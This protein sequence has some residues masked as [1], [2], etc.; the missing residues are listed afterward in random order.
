MNKYWKPW[1]QII[2]RL[3]C[4][5][6][7]VVIITAGWI[8]E[9]T[10][11]EPRLMT[12]FD[13][14]EEMPPALTDRGLFF[15]PV[16]NGKYGLAPGDGFHNLDEIP[17]PEI[18]HRCQ[19]PFMLESS[20][21]GNSEAAR[22]DLAFNSGLISRF[23]GTDRL[24]PTIRGRK[25]S[26]TFRF[27]VGPVDFPPVHSVQ[28]EV[29]GGYE[30]EREIILIEAKVGRWDSFH[31]RQLYYPYRFW[32]EALPGKHVR[33]VFLRCD[34]V[35]DLYCLYEFEFKDPL[36]YLSIGL[37]KSEKFKVV[38]APAEES[39]EESPAIS[40]ACDTT[41]AKKTFIP[42][43]D[44]IDRIM[45]IPFMV[46]EGLDT[47]TAI[48]TES[49]ISHRQ[50]DYY[51]QACQSLGLIQRERPR[52]SLTSH[53]ERFVRMTP[54]QRI[55]LL[56]RQ[57]TRLPIIRSALSELYREGSLTL[58]SLTGI[59]GRISGL[60]GET[61]RRRAKSLLA[62]LAW[63]GGAT[64]QVKTGKDSVFL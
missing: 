44:S 42:Q 11:M 48:S 33:S 17:G 41:V 12:K 53:G 62:W 6:L 20:R 35:D 29:D 27:R 36:D 56:A 8:K 49:G 9:I 64:G 24:Y 31:I 15:L 55:N 47:A 23:T 5:N 40:I 28:V 30:G 52:L 63:L 32:T 25:Y 19:L 37:V 3:P 7:G 18:I 38:Q 58:G 4:H 10:G 51:C 34:P 14:R 22:V 45:A 39:L 61:L 50:A 13:R 2:S 57:M 59:I 54:G 43:A 16:T 46:E 21:Y 26:P 1:E 60:S